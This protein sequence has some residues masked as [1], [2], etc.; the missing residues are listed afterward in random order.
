MIGSDWIDDPKINDPEKLKRLKQ[1][2]YDKMV[3]INP[4]PFSVALTSV[5]GKHGEKI[6][7]LHECLPTAARQW[8][9]VFDSTQVLIVQIP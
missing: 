2:G 1:L 9:V 4:S 7:D 5:T 6:M 8:P 3:L